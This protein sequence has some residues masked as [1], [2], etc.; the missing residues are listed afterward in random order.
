MKRLGGKSQR[1]WGGIE[2]LQVH[3]NTWGQSS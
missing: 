2:L 1:V 3:G